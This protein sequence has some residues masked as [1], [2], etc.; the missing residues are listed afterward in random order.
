MNED[1]KTLIACDLCGSEDHALLFVK[2]G[3]RHVRCRA[4]GLVFVNPRLTEHVEIQRRSGTGAMGEDRLT[5]SQVQRL[6][7]ELLALEPFRSRNR[8]L[9]VGAG[10]G[11]FL[12]EASRSGWETWAVEINAQALEH[13]VQRDCARVIAQPAES[14][15]APSE[16]V[17]VARMWDVIEHLESPRRTVENIYRVLRPGGLLRLSTTNFA[18]LSRWLNG[19]EWVYL[20]GSDHIFLFEPATITRLLERAGFSEIQVRTRSFNMRRK[21]YHP[22]KELPPAIP[23]LFP[24]RKIIDELMRF[25]KYGHQMIVTALKPDSVSSG[26][27]RQGRASS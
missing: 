27:A 17:D 10:R 8:I 11:W 1:H 5:S 7:R 12:A 6:R 26:P 25:T 20:N 13:L 24:L 18:S 15:E 22:E 14:F 21:L 3:Y 23:L 2:E 9:E 16:Y 4:C 19:P